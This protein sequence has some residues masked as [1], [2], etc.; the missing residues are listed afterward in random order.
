MTQKDNLNILSELSDAMANAVE[1]AAAVGHFLEFHRYFAEKVE[2]KP[3][4]GVDVFRW[5]PAGQHSV[6]GYAGRIKVGAMIRIFRVVFLFGRCI[7]GRTNIEV[8]RNGCGFTTQ[9]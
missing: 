9:F 5:K 1:I 4:E 2:Y 3:A 8:G 7:P 6:Q